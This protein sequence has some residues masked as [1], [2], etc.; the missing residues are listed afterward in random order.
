MSNIN[1][2]DNH[3]DWLCQFQFLLSSTFTIMTEEAKSQE[4]SWYF[5]NLAF[6]VEELWEANKPEIYHYYSEFE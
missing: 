4:T 1:L 5:A 2:L 6:E 3:M